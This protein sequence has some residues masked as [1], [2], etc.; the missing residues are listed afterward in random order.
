MNLSIIIPV[1][2]EERTITEILQR[3]NCVDFKNIEKEI[4]VVDD[5]STDSTPQKIAALKELKNFKL[6]NIK[7]LRH[8][9][10]LGKG[11][12]IKTGI[13]KAMGDYFAIQDADLEYNPKDLVR[14]LEPIKKGKT[15]VVYGTRLKRWPHLFG[16]ERHPRFLIHYFGNKI[17]SL[18]ASLL[19][20]QWLTDMETCYKIFPK[21]A[22]EKFNLNSKGFDFE[23]EITAKLLKNGYRILEMP[24]TT[25]PRSYQEGKKLD[26]LRDGLKAL[27]TIL[28]YRVVN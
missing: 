23:P 12:A 25:T 4:I 24:I 11:A 8:K 13:K 1:F 28:K 17:L 22:V 18:I 19:Y 9:E 15:Q 14:L 20:G 16:E 10:N 3:V 26:T 27:L 7:F 5:G 6:N 2:N 21:K